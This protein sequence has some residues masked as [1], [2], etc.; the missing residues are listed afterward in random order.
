M[1]STPG[2]HTS[3]ILAAKF[4][5]SAERLGGLLYERFAAGLDHPDVVHAIKHMAGDEDQH[6]RWYEEWLVEHGERAPT[7]DTSETVLVPTVN[8]LLSPRSLDKQLRTFAKGE[9]TGARHL[10]ALAERIRDPALRSIVLK[11]VPFERAHA[12]WYQ[13][14]GR[15]M[16]RPQ[17]FKKR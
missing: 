8:L 17:D 14:Q 9:A 1:V 15:S 7:L 11:T 4:F 2:A 6:A 10:G 3:D 12:E 5:Y 13:R 16:L